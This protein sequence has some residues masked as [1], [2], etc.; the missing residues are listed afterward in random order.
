MQ[1]PAQDEERRAIDHQRG[2]AVLVHEFG[3]ILC[4]ERRGKKNERQ[5]SAKEMRH[6]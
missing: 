5:S 2:A 6:T 1:L 3:Q 4:E